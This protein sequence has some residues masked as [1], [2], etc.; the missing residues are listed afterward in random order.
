MGFKSGLWL[1]HYRKVRNSPWSYSSL[2]L[3]VHFWLFS[4]QK[5]NCCPSLYFFVLRNAQMNHWKF[6]ELL[7]RNTCPKH[8]A[9]SVKHHLLCSA[10]SK[11][12]FD[13]ST[14]FSSQDIC[15]QQPAKKRVQTK[16]HQEQ[17]RDSGQQPAQWAVLQPLSQIHWYI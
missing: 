6:L 15:S 14:V 13:R 7:K 8:N 4:C 5:V 16:V 3:T 12:R 9:K 10:F 1:G 2:V 11:K 17:L